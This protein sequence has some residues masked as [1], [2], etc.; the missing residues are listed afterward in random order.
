[1]VA[2]TAPEPA[3]VAS[4]RCQVASISESGAMPSAMAARKDHMSGKWNSLSRPKGPSS[5]WRSSKPYGPVKFSPRRKVRLP[6]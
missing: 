2:M 3:Q 1:M 4:P 6:G 5:Y